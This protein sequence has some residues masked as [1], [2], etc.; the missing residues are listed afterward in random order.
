MFLFSLLLLSP[1]IESLLQRFKKDLNWVPWILLF[2]TY[3]P[4][5]SHIWPI[6]IKRPI[7]IIDLL[8]MLQPH[9]YPWSQLHTQVKKHAILCFLLYIVPL[10]IVIEPLSYKAP[11]KP[12]RTA[13]SPQEWKAENA[14]C[15]KGGPQIRK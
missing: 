8:Q 14:R 5:S 12:Y 15:Q 7:F 2:I 3:S 4:F 10:L 11:L 6:Y 13:R 9:P 1:S